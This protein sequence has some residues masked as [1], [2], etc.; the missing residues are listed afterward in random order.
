MASAL[1]NQLDILED[2]ASYCERKKVFQLFE[3]LLQSV[4][5]DRPDQPLDYLIKVLGREP[6]A[7]VIVAGP[8]GAQAASVCE[9]LA[10]KTGLVHVIA[11]DVWRELARLNSAS[12]LEAKSLVENGLE[13]PDELLLQ[14]LKEKLTSGECVSNG[15]VMEGFPSTPSQ[16]RA[17]LSQGLIPTRYLHVAVSDAEVLRRLTGRRVDPQENRVYHL[18]DEPP[19]DAATAGR[20]VQRGADTHEAV[21][22]RLASYRQAMQDVLPQFA[23]TLVELDG[24]KAGSAGVDAMID[25]IVGGGLVTTEMPTRAP[26]GCPRVLLLG[27]PG[28]DLTA[29]GAALAQ[30]YGVKCIS[31]IDLLHAAAINGNKH[32]RAAMET[33]EP[34]KMAEAQLGPIVIDRLQQEDV[35]VSGFVLIGFPNTKGQANKL[36]AA[37][38]WLRDVVHV[39][40]SDAAATA[41]VCGRRYDPWDGELYHI[42]TNMPL[43]PEVAARLVA[44]PKHSKAVVKSQLKTWNQAKGPLLDTYKA[45]LRVEDATRPERALV[46]RLAPCFLSL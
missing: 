26:R 7:R 11:S 2:A 32:A 24:S 5:V 17:M 42:D 9:L 44:H 15:W 4:L 21:S 6:T 34:L 19:P 30:R 31:A 40:M 43:E 37:G 13:V 14:M 41:A 1:P 3:S 27:G 20:L 36:K 10:S 29:L 16:A 39:E 38:V 8:P 35:R 45:E 25:K 33:P 18:T 22:E 23:K 28:A 12:G 46:E